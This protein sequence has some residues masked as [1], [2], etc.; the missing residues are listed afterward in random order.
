MLQ[1]LIIEDE[2]KVARFIQKGLAAEGM[3]T[4]IAGTGEE[5]L[6]LAFERAFDVIALDLSLPGMDGISVIRSLRE[7]RNSAPL[8]VLSARG[9]LEDKLLGFHVGADDYLPKPF[10]FEELVVRI[11]ALA[12]RKAAAIQDAT[13]SYADLEMDLR[14]RTVQ[15]G[16]KQIELTAREFNLLE[17]FLRNPD[18]VLT[19]AK[20]GEAVWHE[21]FERET[22][23]IEVYMMYL[24]KKISVSASSS[25]LLQT[26][27]GV[28]YR[29]CKLPE[30][31]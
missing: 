2:S 4:I 18:Q 13:L 8:L 29:L 26:V 16:S 9:S 27:R 7:R 14:R 5:G 22:N 28:G 1:I 21:Q 19:R 30:R 15:R 17:L 20:I 10:A 31:E 23:V 25:P 6:R 3:E 11:R 24:R 12:R